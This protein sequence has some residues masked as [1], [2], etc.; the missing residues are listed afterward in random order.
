MSTAP[1][2]IANPYLGPIV[3]RWQ[4]EPEGLFG[5]FHDGEAWNKLT[6]AGFM[7]RALQFAALYARAGTRQGDI[8]LIIMEHGIDAHAAFAGAMLIGAVPGFMPSPSVKQD[9]KLYWRQHRAVFSHAQPH[10][11]LV[12][13]ALVE[14]VSEAAE[15]TGTLVLPLS[16]LGEVAPA[17]L[18]ALPPGEAVGLLQHSSGTTGLKK[19]VKLSFQAIH[20]QLAAYSA[21]LALD[22][23]AAPRIVS[24][25]PLYHDMGLISS[26]L[27]PMWRGIPIISIDPFEWTGD[28]S[29]FFKAIEE[30]SGTHAWVPNFALRHQVKTARSKDRFDLSSLVAIICCSEPN[31]PE[32][33]DSFVERFGAWGVAPGTIQACYAMAETVF[34]M[35]QSRIGVPVRRL[36]VD[37]AALQTR[38]S[39]EAPS[40][41]QA[42][43]AL[44]SN[45][46]PIAGCEIRI[47][48]DD[49]FVGERIVGEVCV[50]AAYLFSGYHNSPA[51][52]EAAFVGPW[53][54]TGD[55]GFVDG[56]EVFIV[57]RLKDV[58]ILNGKNV[59]AHDVE[60]AVS[61]V[62]GVKPGRAVAFGHYLEQLGSEQ[63]VVI[64]ETDGSGADHESLTG[65][66]NKAV[67]EDIG[68]T[69]GDVKLVEP[70]WLV[71]TTSGKMS[72][73]ENLT[74]YLHVLV[75]P[76]QA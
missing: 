53:L 59:F 25:L 63:L 70:G 60:A 51:L 69:C 17:A 74:K 58:I 71:K 37:R 46:P 75:E 26:F 41:G 48:R 47:R 61:R 14:A 66:V 13:D 18:G 11:I 30:F 50:G 33:F 31:K 55:L 1:G 67:V 10:A 9:A 44:L 62:A 6:N 64:A 15:G 35:T 57:G 22:A 56:G 52:S 45:G 19:G 16:A 73:S 49:D 5:V 2:T 68:V 23:V 8:V 34:A 4:D 43:L 27:L 28:P 65:S 72:R 29:L 21:A 42:P 54:R 20:D 36:S 12:Y 32:A 7:R 39:V 3:S 24:W 38:Q 40:P 76:L